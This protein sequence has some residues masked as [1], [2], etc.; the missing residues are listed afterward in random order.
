MNS[1]SPAAEPS[2]LL[3]A[4]DADSVRRLREL[5]PDGRHG[6]LQRV[7]DTFVASLRQE[8]GQVERARVDA[9]RAALRGVAH[10]LKSSSR[11][12][13]ALEL[14]HHCEEVERWARDGD[15]R[16]ID[17]PL[18]AMVAQMRRLLALAGHVGG[19]PS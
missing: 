12:V 14:A 17:L 18:D 5:D 13:G 7:L 15:P 3:D 8:L 11:S 4:L 10:K 2:A 1:P 9:D 16:P 19:D 6:L